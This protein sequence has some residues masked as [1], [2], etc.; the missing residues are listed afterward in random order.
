MENEMRSIIRDF[1]QD[2][3]VALVGASRNRQKW[4]NMLFRTLKK[5]GYKVYPVNRNAA[6]IEGEKCYSSLA[7]LPEGAK[8]V[9][10]TI[11]PEVTEQ[12]VKECARVG[13]KRVWMHKGAGGKGAESDAAIEYCKKNGIDVVYGICPLMFFPS[14]GIHKVHFWFK[15]IAGKLPKDFSA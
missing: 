4:G 7:E 11:P 12:I 9:I 2:K 1:I 15:K 6:R 5:K 13:I 10:I 8:N 3:N 14:A